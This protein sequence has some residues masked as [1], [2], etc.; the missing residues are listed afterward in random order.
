M[1][2]GGGGGRED[3]IEGKFHGVCQG[4]GRILMSQR[5]GLS[6]TSLLPEKRRPGQEAAGSAAAGVQGRSRRLP[7]RGRRGTESGLPRPPGAG[8][9]KG[10]QARAR[11]APNREQTLSPLFLL[12]PGLQFPPR[13]QTPRAACPFCRWRCGGALGTRL[14]VRGGAQPAG[15][16]ALE[17]GSRERGWPGRGSRGR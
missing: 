5:I 3:G 16:A 12:L 8:A 15:I 2:G 13:T 10:G 4:R 11:K 6:V 14:R 1:G 7:V 9:A 17:G